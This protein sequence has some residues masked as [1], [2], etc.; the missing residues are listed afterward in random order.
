MLV[1]MV[2]SYE[3]LQRQAWK[4]V[5][6][7]YSFFRTYVSEDEQ[8]RLNFSQ[9]QVLTQDQKSDKDD[10]NITGYGDI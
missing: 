3:K 5:F 8:S 1:T 2:N 4:I 10:S 9:C 6:N 7:V